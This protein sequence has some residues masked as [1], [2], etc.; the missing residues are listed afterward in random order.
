VLLGLIKKAMF[1]EGNVPK[2]GT[3]LSSFLLLKSKGGILVGKM[4]KP[5]I[6]VARFF[7]GEMFA[8]KYAASNKWL[9]P[10][11]HLKYGEKPEDAA[12][13][14][15][16]EQVGAAKSKLSL[17]QVQSHLSQDPNDPEAAHWDICFVYGGTVRGRL[18]IPEW[19]SELKF[20]KPRELASEDFTRGHG[21]VLRELGVIKR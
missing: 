1:N 13:R 11:S 16:V 10:A 12:M 18:Q 15:L 14:I 6:W 17:L 8:P 2:G 5:E 20:M 19:F 9:L 4:T 7:V 21:D 3:C